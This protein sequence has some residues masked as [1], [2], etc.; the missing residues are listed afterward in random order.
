MKDSHSQSDDVL[1]I[2][3]DTD[4]L[5]PTEPGQPKWTVRVVDDDEEVHH[6]TNLA[7]KDLII[8]QRHLP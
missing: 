5:N 8:E 6:A 4:E 3:E 1:T 7:L 2:I